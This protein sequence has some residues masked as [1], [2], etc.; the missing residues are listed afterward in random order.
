MEKVYLA[1]HADD[2]NFLQERKRHRYATSDDTFGGA[3]QGA[4][5]A[6]DDY[7]DEE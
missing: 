7:E 3:H 4:A 2:A 5:E 6:G 1:Q